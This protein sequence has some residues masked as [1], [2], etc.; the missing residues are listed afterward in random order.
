MASENAPPHDY[1][2]ESRDPVSGSLLPSPNV[3][4][5]YADYSLAVAV[6]VKSVADPT[7]QEIRV[8]HV[9]SGEVVF[10]STDPSQNL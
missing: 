4:H 9:P 2:I 8:V 5:L 3:K 6:A 7:R 1:R 10:R